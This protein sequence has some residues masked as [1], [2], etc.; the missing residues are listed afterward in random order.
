M[1]LLR[2]ASLD[3]LTWQSESCYVPFS[4]SRAVGHAQLADFCTS[5][6][7]RNHEQR[8]SVQGEGL[9]SSSD[10][11]DDSSSSGESSDGRLAY[12]GR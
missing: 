1:N 9:E 5:Q 10:E 6:S 7:P 8:H 3:I 4:N 2:R 11:S 12:R